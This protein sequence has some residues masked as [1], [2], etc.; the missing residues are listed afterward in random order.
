M[1]SLHLE[2]WSFLLFLNVNGKAQPIYDKHPIVQYVQTLPVVFLFS[3][4]VITL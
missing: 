4:I 2:Y 1:S 3:V